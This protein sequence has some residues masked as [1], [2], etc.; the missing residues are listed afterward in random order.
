MVPSTTTCGEVDGEPIK[1]QPLEGSLPSRSSLRSS[2]FL[3]LSVYF[4]FSLSIGLIE[5]Q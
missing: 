1:R 3:L 4:R 5:L 2:R